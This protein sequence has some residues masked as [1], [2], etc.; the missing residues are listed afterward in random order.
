MEPAATLAGFATPPRSDFPLK[1]ERGGRRE[2]GSLRRRFFETAMAARAFCG[3]GA[4]KPAGR[5]AGVFGNP[6]KLFAGGKTPP[7]F[8]G[9]DGAHRDAQIGGDMFQWKASLPPPRPERGGKM[10]PNIAPKSRSPCHGKISAQARGRRK[11][12]NHQH[13]RPHP[14]RTIGK[15]PSG[16]PVIADGQTLRSATSVLRLPLR[17]HNGGR[18]LGVRWCNPN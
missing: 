3:E 8:P 13:R 10:I 17:R 16:Q 4:E 11:R 9:I 12:K 15:T 2:L 14:G 18:G 1:V 7:E 6:V 5:Q